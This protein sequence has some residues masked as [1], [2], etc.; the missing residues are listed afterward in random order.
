MLWPATLA[1]DVAMVSRVF[2]LGADDVVLSLLP[3]HHTFEFTCGM[4]L[5]LASGATIAYPLEVDAK[6]L[7]RTLADIRPTALLG[8]PAVWE[9]THRRIVDD[10]EARGPSFHPAFDRFRDPN[11]RF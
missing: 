9:A 7:S 2:V 1:A 11:R 6:T 5:P 4:L 10:V 8:V 3:L